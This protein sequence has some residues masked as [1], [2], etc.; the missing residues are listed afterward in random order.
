VDVVL[1]FEP[2]EVLRA[3]NFGEPFVLKNPDLA[4]S[5][6]IEGLAFDLSH[7]IHKNIPPAAPTAAWKRVSARMSQQK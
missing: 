6:A 4:I 2:N 1:P 3:I 7:E 5:A